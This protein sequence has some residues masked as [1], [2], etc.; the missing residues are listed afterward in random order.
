MS[1]RG[2]QE[3]WIDILNMKLPNMIEAHRNSKTQVFLLY[4]TD[5]HTYPEHV[6]P[7]IEQLNVCGITHKD[8]VEH[9]PVHDM[10][11]GYFREAIKTRLR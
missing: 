7:L 2:K 9:F 5:E 1:H 10:V 3:E 8:Q 11:G 4:S 6:K